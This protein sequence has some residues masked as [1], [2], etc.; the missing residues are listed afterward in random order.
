[1]P[2][3]SQQMAGVKRKTNGNEEMDSGIN[4]DAGGKA[5]T[6]ILQLKGSV[7]TGMQQKSEWSYAQWQTF[8][9]FN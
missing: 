3:S 9:N 2:P 6:F 1:M 8:S 7:T 5:C 4:Q